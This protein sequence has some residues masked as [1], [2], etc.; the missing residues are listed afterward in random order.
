MKFSILI[1]SLE[2]RANQLRGLLD[3]LERQIVRG[4]SEILTA[5]D[6]RQKPT[7]EKRN[8]LIAQAKG[9]YIAFVDDD[10]LV[11]DNYVAKILE[12]VKTDPDCVGINGIITFDGADP[13]KFIHSLRY[14]SWFEKDEI[15]YRC[16]NHL[17]PVKRSIALQVPFP[18]IVFGEDKA[19][20]DGLQ[21]LLHSEVYV[22]EPIYYYLYSQPL[23]A[24]P[25]PK[26]IVGP[27]G[28]A[29]VRPKVPSFRPRRPTY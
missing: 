23:K 16:P 24:K 27:R 9:D 28:V 14:N 18:N 21:K 3:L 17:N 15:Y 22:E 5:V 11:A 20:S 25:Q 2:D 6:N 8:G 12:A 19:Y 7:G 4:Q 26:P 1:C 10:D 13:R 29:V